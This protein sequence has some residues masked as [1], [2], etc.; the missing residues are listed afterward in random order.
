[1]TTEKLEA[2]QDAAIDT[3]VDLALTGGRTKDDTDGWQAAAAI[4]FESAVTI[5][6]IGADPDPGFP[7]AEL[8]DFPPEDEPE[9]DPN[10]Q[11]ALETVQPEPSGETLLVGPGHGGAPLGGHG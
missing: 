8:P 11:A 2:A 3:L 10:E 9:P 7:Y 6:G 5:L 1:M 4:R